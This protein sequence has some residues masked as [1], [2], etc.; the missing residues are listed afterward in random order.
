[1]YLVIGASGYLGTYFLKNILKNTNESIIATFNSTKPS[2]ENARINWQKVDISNLHEVDDFCKNLENTKE[3]KVI[4]LSAYHHPDKVES[5]FP[6]AWNINI[7]ALSN[8]INKIPNIKTFYY[9]ST[10]GVYGESIDEYSFKEHDAH[11]PLNKYAQQKSIAETIVLGYGYNVI[12][13]PFLI[14]PGPDGK[15]HFYDHLVEDLKNNKPIKMFADS[16]RSSLDFDSAAHYTIKL[17]EKFQDNKVGIVNVCADKA[18]SKYDVGLMIAEKHNF[19]KNNVIPILT[20][21]NDSGIFI[22]KRPK[23]TIMDNNKLKNF[24]KL[25]N[26]NIRI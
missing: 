19:N 25:S 20:E 7:V 8:L 16:Y 2:I 10:D 21:E 4:Y 13:Y 11:N 17:I 23:S 18:I 6:L 24:L 14:G 22:A 12:H 1:M 26:I 3:I 5:N 9:S 15:K